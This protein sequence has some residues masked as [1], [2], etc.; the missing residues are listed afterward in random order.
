MLL[1]L[2]LLTLLGFSQGAQMVTRLIHRYQSQDIRVP[3]KYA[4]LISGVPP[5][6]IDNGIVD[7]DSLHIFGTGDP[8]YEKSKILKEVYSN[9]KAVVLEHNEGHNIPSINTNTYSFIKEWMDNKSSPFF[10]GI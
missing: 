6:E 4:I 8:F 7:I 10:Q 3:F 1:L 9:E 2:L 5:K